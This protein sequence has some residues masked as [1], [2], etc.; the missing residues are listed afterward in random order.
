MTIEVHCILGSHIS[1]AVDESLNLY[2]FTLM[3]ILSYLI[4]YF[5]ATHRNKGCYTL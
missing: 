1:L 3:Q 2:P 4:T 5:I